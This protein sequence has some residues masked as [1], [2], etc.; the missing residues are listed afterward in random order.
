M[1]FKT[2]NVEDRA[3][4]ATPSVGEPRT[5]AGVPMA[6]A[7]RCAGMTVTGGGTAA[8]PTAADG[9]GTGTLAAPSCGTMDCCEP[10]TRGVRTGTCCVPSAR[11]ACT[12]TCTGAKT[13]TSGD[14]ARTETA[15][16]DGDGAAGVPTESRGVALRE[17][18]RVTTGV[19]PAARM[20]LGDGDTDVRTACTGG[21]MGVPAAAEEE[22]MPDVGSTPCSRM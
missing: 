12:G 3:A 6:A 21:T 18:G 10:R 5:T 15:A 22:A 13:G 20:S 7:A 16:A 8:L 9:D 17:H 14:G 2:F 19:P 1:F 11:D 4:S